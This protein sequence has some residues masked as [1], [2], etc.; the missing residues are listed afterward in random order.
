MRT[1]QSK[2][3]VSII[4]SAAALFG[5]SL[6]LRGRRPNYILTQ[7]AQTKNCAFGFGQNA[8]PVSSLLGSILAV[9]L[10]GDCL[11]E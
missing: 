11:D 4:A 2:V 6:P 8:L 5:P 9:Q 7:A 10:G 1:S 3:E